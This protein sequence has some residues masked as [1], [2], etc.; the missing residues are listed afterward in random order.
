M[1]KPASRLARFFSDPYRLFFPFAVLA[2]LCG[3][4]NWF[5]YNQGLVDYYSGALHAAIQ[6]QLCMG[7]FIAGFLMTAVPRMSASKYAQP[8]E[9]LALLGLSV[10]M[11]LAYMTNRLVWG[12]AGYILWL[13]LLVRFMV[14]RFKDRRREGAPGAKPPVEFIWI[15]GGVLLGLT[16]AVCGLLSHKYA[17]LAHFSRQV[18]DQGF[19]LA[20]VSGVGGFMGARLTGRFHAAPTGQPGC[21]PGAVSAG[22]GRLLLFHGVCL[23]AFAASFVL[24]GLRMDEPAYLV[25]ALALTASFCRSGTL[26]KWPRT[27]HFYVWVIWLSF[28]LV[29]LGLWGCF[30]HAEYRKTTLHVSFLGG[31]GLMT[32][33]VATMVVLSHAGRA[34]QIR[35]PL[36]VLI[37]VTIAILVSLGFRIAAVLDQENFFAF[38]SAASMLWVGAGVVWLVL[39]LP[40]FFIFPDPGKVSAQHE[41][42]KKSV[43]NS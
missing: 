22:R 34:E 37:L 17:G 9:T 18:M 5:L 23:A 16:G 1:N 14:V 13:C 28:W 29:I 7:G 35:K 33:M 26:P 8:G 2:G 24:E 21:A 43:Q 41:R 39:M 15:P 6:M 11:L 40:C 27:R 36:P 38:V 31:L 20:V 30:F 25:R 3:V 4:G 32:Y 19:V 12:Q 42:M 10:L